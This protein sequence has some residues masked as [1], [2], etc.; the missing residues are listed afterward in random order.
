MKKRIIISLLI[1]TIYILGKNYLGFINDKIFDEDKRSITFE[2]QLINA[3]E[4]INKGL[5]ESDVYSF[6]RSI[7]LCEIMDMLRKDWGMKY[8]FEK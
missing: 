2:Y 4:C 3:T 8:P 6:Q 7:E 1:A 5:I